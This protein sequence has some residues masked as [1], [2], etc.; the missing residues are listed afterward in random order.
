MAFFP[1]G[2]AIGGII[3][4]FPAAAYEK[5]ASPQTFMRPCPAK[6]THIHELDTQQWRHP[7]VDGHE[8]NSAN[9]H[10]DG[11]S[12]HSVPESQTKTTPSRVVFLFQALFW[13]ETDPYY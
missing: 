2:P 12:F 13:I 6:K 1:L 10:D 4:R 8:L 3:R 5:V 11:P 7:L 9:W